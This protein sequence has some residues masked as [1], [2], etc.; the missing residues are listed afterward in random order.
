MPCSHILS[1]GL[2]GQKTPKKFFINWS[3]RFVVFKWLISLHFIQELF[4]V[5]RFYR[6]KPSHLLIGDEKAIEIFRAFIIVNTNKGNRTPARQ[7]T[8]KCIAIASIAKT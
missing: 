6:K 7:P 5:M 3:K 1:E 4:R 8:T 2:D